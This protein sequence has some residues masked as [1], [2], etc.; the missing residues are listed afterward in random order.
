LWS[1]LSRIVAYFA[2][3]LMTLFSMVAPPEF[4]S[5]L[6]LAAERSQRP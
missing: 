6:D 2:R 4:F 5:S 3:R 1:L